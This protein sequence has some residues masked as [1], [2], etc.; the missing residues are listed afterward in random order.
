MKLSSD[1][2]NG[3]KLTIFALSM[4]KKGRCGVVVAWLFVRLCDTEKKEQTGVSM[5]FV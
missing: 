5:N 4:F 2:K 3:I 1:E